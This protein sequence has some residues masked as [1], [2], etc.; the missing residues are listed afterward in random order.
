MN[1]ISKYLSL[2]KFSLFQPKHGM[3]L[4]QTY[5]DVNENSKQEIIEHEYV[6]LDI[7]KCLS[8][9][10]PNSDIKKNDLLLQTKKPRITS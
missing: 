4:F 9:V 8:S 2:I 6:G 10:F 5:R 3:E 1:K 7:E